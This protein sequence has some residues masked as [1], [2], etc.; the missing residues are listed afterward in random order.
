ML[1]NFD[2]NLSSDVFKWITKGLMEDLIDNTNEIRPI[3]D[4]VQGFTIQQIFSAL[5]PDVTT[6]PA[7]RDRFI[8]QNPGNQNLQTTDLFAQYHY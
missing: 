2:P 7:Y 1:E 8:Q 3:I 6:V 4:N 5:Q